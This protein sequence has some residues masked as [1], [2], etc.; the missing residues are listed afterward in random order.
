M[1]RRKDFPLSQVYGLLEP[2][3][4]VLLSTV[5]AGRLNVMPVSWHTMLECVP[6]LVGCVVSSAN[7]TF[8]ALR[9]T[10]ECVINIPTA[11]LVGKVVACGSASGKSVDK[12]KQCGL[13]PL[14]GTV[15]QA[16]LV[17]ECYAHLECQ[18]VDRNLVAKYNFFVLE[19]V[20]AWIDPRRKRPRTIH[21][22]GEWPVL[23][24]RPVRLL[25]SPKT[26]LLAT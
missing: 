1:T 17:A 4:V 15:V 5:R 26:S 18:V 23:R 24:A 3:P 12:F 22:R 20:K 25:P 10:D 8:E 6:P 16:P 11:Q 14:P 21:H 9:R 7:Y 19:V 13:T 2:G